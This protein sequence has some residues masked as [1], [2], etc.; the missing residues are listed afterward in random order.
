M[1]NSQQDKQQTIEMTREMIVKIKN[2]YFQAKKNK[3]ESFMV[4]QIE[5][6]TAYAGY[7]LEHYAPKFDVRFDKNAY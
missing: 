5:F 4:G 7:F 2:S 1:S 6:N 3:S